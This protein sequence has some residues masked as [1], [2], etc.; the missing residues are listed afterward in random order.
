M[1]FNSSLIFTTVTAFAAFLGAVM[2]SKSRADSQRIARLERKL[3]MVLNHLGIA[4]YTAPVGMAPTATVGSA[5]P[6]TVPE[7]ITDE[8]R[9]GRKINAI[10]LYRDQYQVGLKEAKDAVD[11]LDQNRQ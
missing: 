7:N 5:Y 11:Q 4:D 9:R 1:T 3:N 6:G 8:L 10:K 2:S